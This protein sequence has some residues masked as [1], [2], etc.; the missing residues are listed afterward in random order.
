MPLWS[1][2]IQ[3]VRSALFSGRAY[4]EW[5]GD[6]L[7]EGYAN[8]PKFGKIPPSAQ[9]G[10]RRTLRSC[11]GSAGARYVVSVGSVLLRS[12]EVRSTSHG[13]LH[14][15]RQDKGVGFSKFPYSDSLADGAGPREGHD[16]SSA[17]SAS[18]GNKYP[19]KDY[20]TKITMLLFYRGKPGTDCCGSSY[21][22]LSTPSRGPKPNMSEKHIIA[23]IDIKDSR[24]ILKMACSSC[25]RFLHVGKIIS[26][27]RI[28]VR[29]IRKKEV[30]V[31]LMSWLGNPCTHTYYMYMCIYTHDYTCL[32][33]CLA[34]G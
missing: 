31:A 18:P 23:T 1:H 14:I 33:P 20:L 29:W 27:H 7:R 10:V 16:P 8:G 13:V 6:R 3:S 32:I 26:S 28:H 25:W 5:P 30:K 21:V 15:S 22:L 24:A 4:L 19:S 2:E 34:C 17:S 9:P 12:S 11:R